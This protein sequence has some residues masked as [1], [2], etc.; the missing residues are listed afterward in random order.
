MN[1]D[2][3]AERT[4]RSESS[5]A[6]FGWMAAL[7]HLGHCRADVAQHAAIWVQSPPPVT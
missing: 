6:L 1:E 7:A 3:V 2:P 5:V 4:R